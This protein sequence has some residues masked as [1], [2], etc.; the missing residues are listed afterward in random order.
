MKKVIVFLFLL[1]C[2]GVHTNEVNSQETIVLQLRWD[3]QFQFAGYYTALWQGYY[4]AEGLDVEIR[5]AVSENGEILSAVEEVISGKADFGIGAADILIANDS[6]KRLSVTAS[7]FQESAAR[8]YLKQDTPYTSL[9]DLTQLRIARRPNDLIDVELQAMLLNEGIDPAKITPY[10]HQPGLDHLL[11][12]QVQMIPGYRTTIPYLMDN[13]DVAY[14][15]VRPLDFG[16]DFYGDSIFTTFEL[17]QTDPELV[18]K[19]TRASIRGWEYAF[20]NPDEIALQITNN[21]ERNVPLDDPL[22]FNLFQANVVEELSLFTIVEVGNINPHRWERMFATLQ[23]IG[24]VNTPLE[25]NQFI[26]DPERIIAERN[27]L[28]RRFVYSSLGVAGLFFVLSLLWTYSLRKQVARQT[29]IIRQEEKRYRD[30]F[31]FAQ[32]GI[33]VINKDSKT[34]IVN[35]SMAKMLGYSVDEMIGKHLYDFM[36]DQG[37]E[38]AEQNLERRQQG[39]A[40][41]HDFEFIRKDGERIFTTLETAPILDDDGNYNGAIAGVIEI[42]QRLQLEAELKEKLATLSRAEKVAQIGSWK[43]DPQTFQITWSPEMYEIFGVDSNHTQNLLEI[44]TEKIHPDDKE[45][46]WQVS[47]QAVE[48]GKPYQIEYRIVMPDDGIKIVTNRGEPILNESGEISAYIGVVQDVT[49][50]KKIEAEIKQHRDHLEEIVAER[51]ES[52]QFLVNSMA[53]REV[54]MAELKATIKKLR[55]QLIAEGFE[56]VADDPMNVT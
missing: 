3:H 48:A 26:F 7:I 31:E 41:Q 39:I 21:L 15:E 53:G 24:L 46:A 30:L 44:G 28:I 18:E 37:V 20:E 5:S 29:N 33:W 42:T 8:F 45:G 6:G 52:L 11:S 36:D 16:V 25:I 4:E 14:S 10:P 35:V 55:Q 34:T 17:T 32:E 43:L 13:A 56:P 22:K 2:L 38:L 9:S 40:E 12:N 54:R 23:K 51:T 1:L 27:A 47:G 19:F 49:Q 50:R